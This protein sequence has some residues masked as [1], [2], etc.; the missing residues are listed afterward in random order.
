MLRYGY[1]TCFKNARRILEAQISPTATICLVKKTQ[2]PRIFSPQ[3]LPFPSWAPRTSRL[4]WTWSL[5]R[6]ASTFGA[7]S[8]LTSGRRTLRTCPFFLFKISFPK[9]EFRFCVKKKVEAE[10]FFF[11]W[12][13]WLLN[14]TKNQR[15]PKGPTEVSW[16]GCYFW[17]SRTNIT[18]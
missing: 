2:R 4:R 6:G 10:F 17:Q 13:G 12:V 7:A 9:R 15:P 1:S 16:D 5:R 3:H 11:S 8:E 18:H 14:G